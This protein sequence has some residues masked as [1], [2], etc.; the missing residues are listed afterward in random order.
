MG[1]HVSGLLSA[2]RSGTRGSRRSPLWDLLGHVAGHPLVH[3]QS[4]AV[5]VLVLVVP[6]VVPH[7]LDLGQGHGVHLVEAGVLA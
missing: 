3:L 6:G 4:G 2:Q 7:V 1:P 5:L